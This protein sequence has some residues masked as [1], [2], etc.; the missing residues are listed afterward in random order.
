MTNHYLMDFDAPRNGGFGDIA[1]PALVVQG[2]VDPV[3]TP[4]H[5]DA[6]VA[7]VPGARLL[8]LP[9]TGHD[10]PPP[11]WDLF[12]GR[13]PGAHGMIRAAVWVPLFDDLADPRVAADL[14]VAAEDGRLGRLLR[15]GPPALAR[16][17]RRGRRSVDRPR[18]GR[19]GD[20]A[21]P[22]GHPGDRGGPTPAGEAG[23]GDG[24]PRPAEQRS[25]GARRRARLGPLRRRVL[26]LRRGGRRAGP[27]SHARRGARG[28]AA[29]VDRR[30]GPPS[31]RLT[32]SSTACG[33]FR[34]RCGARSR[35]GSPAFRERRARANGRRATT[36]SSRS[37]SPVRTSSRRRSRQS[38][39]CARSRRRRTTSSRRSRPAPTPRPT[40]TAGATW[41][42]TDV[43]AEGLTLDRVRGFIAD[44][45][46]R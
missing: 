41:C 20:G 35:S 39:R 44:G 6:L 11:V 37:T 29:S 25:G 23:P 2:E 38:A 46:L 15:L 36:G 4:P 7:A 12:V 24:R 22:A 40:S 32:T 33:S 16:A 31:R 10:V 18:R 26:A 19:R 3:F 13:A 17:G 8:V 28:D 27:R 45:P 34:G 43:E 1:V 30:A 9:A 21:D 42:V 5:G 14:A